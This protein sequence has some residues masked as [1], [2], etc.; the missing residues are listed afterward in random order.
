[1]IKRRFLINYGSDETRSAGDYTYTTQASALRGFARMIRRHP[2]AHTRL[3]RED[4][5]GIVV[6]REHKA[7]AT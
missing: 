1:M 6:I 5:G 2:N 4:A 3:F 7:D